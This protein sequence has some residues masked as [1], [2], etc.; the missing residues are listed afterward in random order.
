MS[1]ETNELRDTYICQ[2][3]I[4]AEIQCCQRYGDGRGK[5][6]SIENQINSLIDNHVELD[7][8]IF[9]YFVGKSNNYDEV[10]K[11]RKLLM[12][13]GLK[14]SEEVYET[15]FILAENYRDAKKI[16]NEMKRNGYKPEDLWYSSM[17][18]K[19]IYEVDFN[20]ALKDY[21]KIHKRPPLWDNIQNFTMKEYEIIGRKE[22]REK[23][24]EN[25]SSLD[26]IIQLKKF[27][28][29]DI[30][31]HDQHSVDLGVPESLD[32][33][34]YYEGKEAFKFHK[35]IERNKKL[36]TDA[37]KLFSQRNAGELFCQVCKFN[38]FKVYG[39]R[40][41][42]FIEAHHIK[43]ISEMKDNVATKIEDLIMLCSNC[44]R[45]IHR[46]PFLTV[47]ELCE[48]VNRNKM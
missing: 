9:A 19:D 45:M 47:N 17:F 23:L 2:S 36:V 27:N 41:D 30:V 12:S 43:P 37:K 5:M 18:L 34:E 38:F 21:E 20:K 25:Y 3:I 35:H 48:I 22:Y 24:I 26:L 7:Y 28:K 13:Y 32:D 14:M 29:I 39:E 4:G 44:H 8:S 1:A 46:K 40:G 42:G 11:I 31:N 33:N 10:K 15:L 16:I 6:D